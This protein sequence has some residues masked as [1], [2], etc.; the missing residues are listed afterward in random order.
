M[1]RMSSV[2]FLHYISTLSSVYLTIS[3]FFF[4][5]QFENIKVVE[6]QNNEVLQSSKKELKDLLKR[7]QTLDIKIQSLHS[8]VTTHKYKQ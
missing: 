3:I 2:F 1:C 6:A 8:T 7:K 4:L 5:L